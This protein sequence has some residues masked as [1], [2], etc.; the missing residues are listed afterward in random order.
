[1]LQ[2]GVLLVGIVFL[3]ATLVVDEVDSLLDRVSV[4]GR[5]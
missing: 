5:Q 3:I 1:M 4:R 2:S